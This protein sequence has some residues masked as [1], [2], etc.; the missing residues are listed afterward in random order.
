MEKGLWVILF[1]FLIGFSTAQIGYDNPNLPRVESDDEDTIIAGGNVTTVGGDFFF[2]NFTDSFDLNYTAAPYSYNQSIGSI[3]SGIANATYYRFFNESLDLIDRTDNHTASD[4]YL[5]NVEAIFGTGNDLTIDSDGTRGIIDGDHIQGG[6]GDNIGLL[7]TTENSG[8]GRIYANIFD[9]SA[10]GTFANYEYSWDPGITATPAATVLKFLARTNDG[11]KTLKTAVF[12][13]DFNATMSS[14]KEIF[15]GV[16]QN[17]FSEKFNSNGKNLS[18]SGWSCDWQNINNN[19]SANSTYNFRC[20]TFTDN[21]ITIANTSI[22]FINY[23]P[24]YITEGNSYI[25]N[26]S[27]TDTLKI[28][29]EKAWV[30]VN[31]RVCDD[32]NCSISVSSGDKVF[33]TATG[34]AN[35][36]LTGRTISLFGNNSLRYSVG[37]RGTNAAEEYPFSLN[38]IYDI[39]SQNEFI[40]NITISSGGLIHSTRIILEVKR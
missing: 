1:L 23:E 13:L 8:K 12:L 27:I 2:A 26:L 25:N 9:T 18:S 39:T 15:G 20:F 19:P 30:T 33:V 37:A 28:D 38:D 11:A 14:N 4:R 21:S 17:E 35:Q 3:S 22:E 40:S 32:D 29:N 10:T 16:V 31:S 6:A 34:Y 7:G 5:D 36:T 24:I